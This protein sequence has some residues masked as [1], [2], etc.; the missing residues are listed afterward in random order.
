MF[1]QFR[2]RAC[3]GSASSRPKC[4]PAGALPPNS[5]NCPKLVFFRP[6]GRH[7]ERIEMKFGV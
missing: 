1:A 7:N 3:A 5:T 4:A 2:G 6:E